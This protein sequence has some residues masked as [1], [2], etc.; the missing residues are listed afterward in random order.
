M[1]S[2]ANGFEVSMVGTRWKLMCVREKLR[3]YVVHV[4]VH[5]TQNG[6]RHRLD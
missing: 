6:L 5:A 1:P 2:A 3:C 4:I